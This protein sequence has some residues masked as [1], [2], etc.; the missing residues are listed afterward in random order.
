MAETVLVLG[1][2]VGGLSAAHELAERG[3]SVTVV[4]DRDDPGGKARSIFV[5]G[6]GTEGREDLPAE[7]GAAEVGSV[8]ADGIDHEVGDALAVLIP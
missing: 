5:G 4:E 7:H 3:F 1:G 2:G 8:A 6:S